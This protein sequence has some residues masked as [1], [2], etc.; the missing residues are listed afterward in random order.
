MVYGKPGSGIANG[1]DERRLAW[2]ARQGRELHAE[3]EH[4]SHVEG[5]KREHDTIETPPLEHVNPDQVDG[6]DIAESSPS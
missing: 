2:L 5:H 6:A 1:R 4:S 3:H